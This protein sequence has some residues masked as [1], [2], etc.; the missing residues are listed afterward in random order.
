MNKVDFATKLSMIKL[1]ELTVLRKFG[2]AVNRCVELHSMSGP[3]RARLKKVT[4]DLNKEYLRLAKKHLLNE[5]R[6]YGLV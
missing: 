1:D 6:Y 2:E 4:E 3:E 5:S